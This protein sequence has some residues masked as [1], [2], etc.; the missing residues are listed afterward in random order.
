VA[1]TWRAWGCP[2]ARPTSEQSRRI[3][4]DETWALLLHQAREDLE[5]ARLRA[6]QLRRRTGYR[7]LV[8]YLIADIVEADE[9]L[10]I[11]WEYATA[12]R[13]QIVEEVMNNGGK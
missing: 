11:L 6:A 2:M 1:E 5:K 7:D 3:E 10:V 9:L 8:N 4:R 12:D 13:E